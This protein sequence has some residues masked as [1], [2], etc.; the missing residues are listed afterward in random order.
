MAI[1]GDLR[2]SEFRNRHFVYGEIINMGFYPD[3][4]LILHAQKPREAEGHVVKLSKET[5]KRLRK[6]DAFHRGL[7][8]MSEFQDRPAT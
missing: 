5:I 4:K 3:T 1:V 6:L 7:L 8:L 2:K